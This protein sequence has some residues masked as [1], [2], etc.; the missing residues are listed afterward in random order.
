MALKKLRL[1]ALIVISPNMRANVTVYSK[2]FM[3]SESAD[4]SW[5]ARPTGALMRR[6]HSGEGSARWIACVTPNERISLGDPVPTPMGGGAR[7]TMYLPSWFMETAGLEDGQEIDMEFERSEDLQKATRLSFK[8]IGDIPADL[9][10]RD[11]LEEPLSQLG[12]MEV[13]QIIPVPAL[14]GTMLLLESCDPDGVV[15]LD[16]ADI[17][18]EIENDTEAN[19]ATQA[20][21][22]A[23]PA[24][25]PFVEAP[26][27]PEADTMLPPTSMMPL[28][29][30]P[31]IRHQRPVSRFT[32]PFIPFQGVGHTLG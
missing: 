31:P 18:L 15:F 24:S 19:A 11:L 16:G 25:S 3:D 28:P 30:P 10:I 22:V 21:E 2:I 8:V 26:P 7:E 20:N 1:M 32:T 13:G 9:D 27:T 5:S 17:A 6:L 29:L 14:E 4:D 12:V 23:I